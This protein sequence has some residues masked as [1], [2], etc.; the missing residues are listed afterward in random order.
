MFKKLISLA[1]ALASAGLLAFLGLPNLGL[2]VGSDAVFHSTSVKAKDVSLVC[3]GSAFAT[4][5]S[6]GTNVSSFSRFGSAIVDYSSNLP[7]GVSLKT[8]P[9]T[10]PAAGR[11]NL[12][13]TGNQVGSLTTDSAVAITVKDTAALTEQGT[14]TFT[15]QSY[16]VASS[17]GVNG[18][19]GTNC[20]LP[21]TESWLVGGVTTVGREALLIIS[22]PA[23]TDATIDLQLFGENGPIDGAGLNGISVSA[24]RTVVLPLAGYAPEQKSLAVHLQSSGAAVASWIQERTVRGTVSAGTDLISPSIPAGTSLTI[25]G[26][27]KRGTADAT[28]LIGNNSD[29]S[30]LTPSIQVLV[31]G[32]RSATVTI[33]VIGVGSKAVGTVLQEQVSAGS[34]GSFD[35]TGLKDG[36]YSV[37]VLADQPVQAAVKLSRTKKGSTPITDFAWL[38]AVDAVSS[39]LA[40]TSA[41]SAISKLSIANG[42]TQAATVTVTDLSKGTA[43]KVAVSHLAS[44]TVEVVAG[45][46]IAVSSDQPVSATLI[47]D[48]TGSIAAI[49]LQDYRNTG[50]QIQVMV[51]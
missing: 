15:A 11:G 17:N 30:D 25:P 28:T 22:N 10:G 20:Q 48:F 44:A 19:L 40:V 8:Q 6:S 13:D 24:N 31:P 21:A 4:G 2:I 5:G 29:Y 39:K 34:T 33:Q 23:A 27:L 14:K 1:I 3:P 43:Q 50:G 35:L 47:A 12:S 7:G 32:E 38:P 18:V 37:F 26:L 49:P 42:G 41:K 46:T 45:D 9:L 16:Q 36:D 51:R